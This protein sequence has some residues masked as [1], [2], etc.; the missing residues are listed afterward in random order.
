MESNYEETVVFKPA[1]GKEQVIKAT[2]ILNSYKRSK[3][4]LEKRIVENE[5]WWKMRH[6]GLIR[7]KAS[8]D[9]EPASAWLFNSIS[10][11]H[12]DVMDN[13]PEPNVLPREKGDA[14]VADILSRILPVVLEYNDFE[15]TYS[16]VWWYKLKMGTG[17]YGVFWNSA[18]NSGLGDIDIRQIDILNIFWEPGIKD[19]QKS[20]NIFTVEMVDKDVLESTYPF[21]RG[22]VNTGVDVA[23]YIY[24]D[25]VDTASK[26]SVVDWYYKKRVGNREVLHYCKYV[27]TEVLY[28]SE[29]DPIYEEKGYYNHGK[30]PFVFD[31]LFIEEGTPCGFGYIDVMKDVQMYIDKL[32]QIIIRNAL[33]AGKRRFF[34]SDNA[35]VNEEE[36]ADWSKE[37]VHVAGNM[38][39]R[40]LKE[41]SVSQLDG[42]VVAL[43]NQ[44]IDELK[45]TSG[46]RDVSQGSASGGVTAASAIAALQEAGTKL[47]RDMIKGS[48]RAFKNIN[49]LVIELICQFY[50]H[51]RTFRICSSEKE[52]DF[53]SF[54]GEHIKNMFESTCAIFDVYVVSR[55]SS[56]FSKAAQNELAKELYGAGIFNPNASVPALTCL[57]MMDFEGKNAVIS[58]VSENAKNQEILNTL[59]EQNAKLTELVNLAY[60][61]NLS[62]GFTEEEKSKPSS[63]IKIS[64]KPQSNLRNSFMGAERL[65]AIRKS[66]KNT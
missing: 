40:N 17:C 28:S 2:E 29:N 47:S 60:G 8:G 34:I 49:H 13:Y 21:L 44:K 16:D 59:K 52:Y 7:N 58:K 31:P 9:P 64:K 4:N 5:Q 65:K 20:R 54:D 48:Y 61:A 36:F 12:A 14:P 66:L 39:E 18:L 41:I 11:K 1:V 15:E 42:G 30:Y 24:D 43:L 19:I 26:V 37:F 50:D 46:N 3:A 33:Q 6:W 51:S 53:V 10:N 63:A 62:S 25:D 45:E 38:D 56:P 23:K 35:G 57:E 27:G 32:N 55:K 22:N